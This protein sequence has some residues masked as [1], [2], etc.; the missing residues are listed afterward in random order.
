MNNSS[1][2]QDLALKKFAGTP[3][4][5]KPNYNWRDVLKEDVSVPEVEVLCPHGAERFDLAE[6]ADTVGKSLANLML[7]KGEKDIFNDKNQRFVADVTREVASNLTQQ[8]LSRGPLRV[9]LNDLYVLIEKTLVD[10]NA[11]DVAKSLLLKRAQKISVDR[12]THGVTVRLI[13][14]NNQVVPWNEAKIEIAVRKAFLSLKKDPTPATAITRAVTARAAALKQTFLHIE[15]VQDMVQE[16]LMKS[17]HFKV[18][19][20]YILYRAARHA[21]RG[22]S[23]TAEIATPAAADGAAPAP[24]PAPQGQNSMIVVQRADGSTYLW[25]GLDLKKRIEFA[26]IGL[27]LCVTPE[28]IEAELRRS[29]FDNIAQGDLNNTIVLNA[30]TLIEK[31]ADFAKFAGRIQLTYIYEEVLGWDI[32]RDGVG[33]L[34][35]FHQQAFAKYVE[36]GVAIKRLSPRLKEY[37][38]ARIAAAIDPTADLELDFLGVQTVYDRY[39]IIDKTGKRSRRLETPQFFWMRVSM[40]LFLDEKS[41][42]EGWAIKLYGLYKSRRF[43]SS[44]P[45][46]FNSGTL[47]SQLSSCY[48]YYVDDSLEGIMYRGIAENAQLSKWAGGLGGSWT[49]VRGTGA[50]IAGTNGE[51]Q[52]V[53][54]FLKLHNDQLVAVNQGGKRKGS[55]CAYLETWHNDIFE[56]LELRRNT[57]DD[58]RRTHDM[59]TANWIPDLFMKRMESRGTWTLFRSNETPDLHETFGRKFEERYAHYEKLAEEGKI[60]GHK[61]EALELWKK[62]LSMLFE[63]GHPWITFKDPCNLR[64]PQDHA[65]VIH[66]SNLCTEITLNT[67]NDET[68]VCNL[69]SVILD[70]H[71]KPDGSLDH[72]KLRDTISVALRALDNVIDIN[73]YPTEAAKRSN[74]RHRPVGLGIMG[75]ANA[76][77]LKGI[78]FASHEAVE[79]N[80]EFMEAIAYYAYEASSDLAA[81]RGTYSSY[82]GSKWDRGLLPQDTLDLLEQE[83]GVPVDVPRGGKMNWEPLR[84][85]I[86]K[87]GMRN[88]NCLAIAPTATISN[89]TNTS[90]CIE[91]Y[92]KN[93]YVKSNLSGEFVVI[94]T[95]LVE[96]LKARGLWNQEM[97]D[98]LKYY[99]GDLRDIE[100]VPADLKEKY[101]TAF[102]ID[103]KWVVDAAARRQKWIDQSQSVNLWLKTPDLKTLS[104]MYRHAWRAGLKTTYYLRTLGASTIEKATVSVKKEMR[105]ATGETT[106]ETATRD[107]ATLSSLASSSSPSA[108]RSYTEAEKN[109][110]SIEAMRNGGT[111]EACQ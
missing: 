75:L 66:S 35:K 60:Q 95:F 83:R 91:P 16:E 82:K 90:P 94:N 93:L 33:A 110:C 25:D 32:V 97:I 7:A 69:G 48:L 101:L 37:D 73:F 43:C 6:V 74:L 41:D 5:Q 11:H 4:D 98:N 63:T 87:H 111:C 62:M 72:E 67:S 104:H 92:Y 100:A 56:F 106:A 96:D 18:A 89:I 2:H 49:A 109:A 42:R 50:H 29:T 84:A 68:A 71:L 44:T 65:G 14:R 15:E 17:G 1:V 40:G 77:Y 46:L 80:D 108:K 38:L 78:A 36:H 59:N 54:P 51:S 70:S 79:F 57:G 86:A 24:A 76:L 53:I 27:K 19:E 58:R 45:T 102:D 31:D 21:A 26:S 23:D 81:E 30:K 39:L 34:R 9:S 99:D 12:D 47:H 88:S 20:D 64:S 10:N 55:G 22:T 107:A 103:H 105:G 13:R 85:K 3:Q 52:G 8:A 28:I 61:V